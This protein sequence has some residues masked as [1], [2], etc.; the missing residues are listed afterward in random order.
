MTIPFDI[1]A[2]AEQALIDV[3]RLPGSVSPHD[4]T[5]LAT[6]SCAIVESYIDLRLST[7]I[8]ESRMD[9]T[10]FG[11]ALL[12]SVADSPFSTWDNRLDWLKRGFEVQ[13]KGDARWERMHAVIEAR[14]SV[15]HGLQSLTDYQIRG[16]V[17]KQIALE[18]GLWKWLGIEV[19]G[20]RLYAS[21][22]TGESIQES[23]RDFLLLADER[24]NSR[25][26]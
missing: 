8:R 15:A 19:I 16:D 11:S 2:A 5:L 22:R 6:H 4:W 13:V 26:V 1:S 20:K 9:H 14:N 25:T 23:C 24:M 12:R 21:E 3:A 7:F 10:P 17:T 18:Q